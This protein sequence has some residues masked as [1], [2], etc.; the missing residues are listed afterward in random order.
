MD[1]ASSDSNALT[2]DSPN[3]QACRPAAIQLSSVALGFVLHTIWSVEIPGLTDV[4]W[5]VGPVFLAVGLLILGFSYREFGRSHTSLRPDEGAAALIRTGPFGRSR[6]PLYLVVC[7][8]IAGI[9]VWVNSV[10]M[11]AM[12]IPLVVLMS[13]AVIAQEEG[14]LERKFG[15]EYLGYKGSVRRWL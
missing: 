2:Q 9:A 15:S 7:L 6:N 11:L 5:V 10:W 13:Y 14:Y 12:L 4:S 3:V 8:L 1:N